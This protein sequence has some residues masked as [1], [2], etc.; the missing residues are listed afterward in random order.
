[1][2]K[3]SRKT[4]PKKSRAA[5]KKPATKVVPAAKKTATRS[6]TAKTAKEITATFVDSVGLTAKVAAAVAAEC[7]NILAGTGYSA[8][9]MRRKATFT[10][11]VDDLIK[12][13]KALEK[14]G[15]DEIQDS[16]VIMVETA[17]KVGALEK[18]SRII[19]NAGIMI[20]YFYSTTSSG[21]TATCVFKTADD[22][23]AIKVLQE[24]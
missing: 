24:A 19:A 23:K 5:T 20:Y 6:F 13:E 4:T 8:S 1:M 7:V 2:A 11:I 18:I 14:I 16:S 12:A 22:K 10:L 17:N 15:A 9:G 3:A 21:K